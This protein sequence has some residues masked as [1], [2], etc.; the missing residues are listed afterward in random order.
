MTTIDSVADRLAIPAAAREHRLR[1][2]L[3]ID[4]ERIDAAPRGRIVLVTAM[5]PTP[6]GEGKTTVSVGLVDG[7]NLRGVRAVGALR[8]PS[9][10][11]VFGVKGGAVGGGRSSVTPPD[12]INLHFTG[13]IH[14][15]TSAHNLLSALLDNHL[16]YAD[17]RADR[18][19]TIAPEA[20]TWGRVMDM[21]D[22]ALR[23]IEVGLSTAKGPRR[24]DRFDITAASEVMAI[25]CLA[26]DVPDL[27]ARLDRI[28]VGFDAA[29]GPVRAGDIKAGGAMAALLLDAV[30]P[31]LVMTLE[32]NPVFLHG[33]PFGNVANGTSS[34]IQTELCRRVGDVVVT[35]GGF[36]FDLG[37]F[38]FLDLKCRAGGFL[39]G[40]VVMVATIRAMR[41]HG[42]SADYA[43]A[44]LP[45][46]ER[47]L[48]NV[49]AHLESMGRI[50]IGPPIVALN[51][52]PGD[53]PDEVAYVNK[54][55]GARG[56]RVVDST[57]FTQGSAGTTELADAVM[58]VLAQSPADSPNYRPI[59]AAEESVPEKLD[60]ITRTVLGGQGV[61]LT[62]HAR[63]DLARIERAGL[64]SMP[65]C[66]AKTHLSISD[67][68][69][70]RG[71]PAPF[72]LT[73]TGLRAAAGAGFIVALCGP[74]LTMPGLASSPHAANVDIERTP[75]GWAIRGLR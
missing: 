57:G 1:G 73:V 21:N 49:L 67:A 28:V 74:I 17:P 37:G 40:A 60:R 14:A 55:L 71:R 38:K 26:R 69:K 20:V 59:Y 68:A 23:R 53:S 19:P 31:N 44:D 33:G 47:G 8:E 7:L 4:P 64:A 29:G 66:L 51:R 15:V 63:A 32:G 16:H 18:P 25:L 30:R 56:V 34:R 36:A 72:T 61:T 41:F 75:S 43:A 70:A 27:R 54:T 9:L 10:G 50:G 39:P 52:F 48:D 22:R 11:P 45:A 58:Q 6:A 42:G 62:D 35:E 46:V 65:I 5:T 13:D 2:V 24:T 12:A 3:K